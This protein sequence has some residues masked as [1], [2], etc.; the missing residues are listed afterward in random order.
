MLA[1]LSLVPLSFLNP[2][3]SS[4]SSWFTLLKLS[5]EDFEHNLSSMWNECNYAVVWIFFDIPLLWHWNES[6]TFPV[7]WPLLR[8]LPTAEDC[9][10]IRDFIYL[11]ECPSGFPYFMPEFCNKLFMIWSIVSSRS[12][13]CW[14][15]SASPSSAGN[16]II[17]MISVLTIWWC[18]FVESPLVLL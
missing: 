8:T 9:V 13:A 11:P 1:I 2:D 14:H 18:P 17:S 12:C 10:I 7:L 16:N 4:G 15:Y 3:F 5:L 6:W